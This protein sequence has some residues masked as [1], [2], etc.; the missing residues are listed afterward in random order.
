MDVKVIFPHEQGRHDFHYWVLDR[1]DSH[2]K[3]YVNYHEPNTMVFLD[4]SPVMLTKL[5]EALEK[6]E[7]RRRWEK[8]AET[9]P[10]VGALAISLPFQEHQYGGIDRCGAAPWYAQEDDQR[11]LDWLEEVHKEYTK[12]QDDVKSRKEKECLRDRKTL[13]LSWRCCEDHRKLSEINSLMDFVSYR[14]SVQS[15]GNPGSVNWWRDAGRPE[16]QKFL[17]ER[18]S[19]PLLEEPE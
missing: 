7:S 5:E 17:A 14:T 12:A 9:I 16:M 8:P 3:H 1:R 19:I 10:F 11:T 4:L 18:W 15:N 13:Y 2:R 6:E